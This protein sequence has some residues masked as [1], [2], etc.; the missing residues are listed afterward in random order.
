VSFILQ[1]LGTECSCFRKTDNTPGVHFN[2]HI[3]YKLGFIH[4]DTELINCCFYCQA[5][6]WLGKLMVDDVMALKWCVVYT[7]SL[8]VAHPVFQ[9]NDG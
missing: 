1:C 5:V 4:Y 8:H 9:R 6:G 7:S 3:D 2:Y